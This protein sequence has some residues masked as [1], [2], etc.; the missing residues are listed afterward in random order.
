VHVT[1]AQAI[2]SV[3]QTVDVRSYPLEGDDP[4]E[5]S[6]ETEHQAEEPEDIH[7]DADAVDSRLNFG[8][9]IFAC[10][11]GCD[12]PQELNAFLSRIREEIIFRFD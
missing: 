8:D 3:A 1:E 5:S 7:A 2:G 6:R 4:D 12:L 9:P 11:L 10:S